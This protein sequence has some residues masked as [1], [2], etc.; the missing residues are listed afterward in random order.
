M[1]SAVKPSN[2]AQRL[3]ILRKYRVLDTSPE[4][5]FDEIVW[6]ASIICKVPVALISLI[7]QDRQWFKAKVGLEAMQ[8]HRD[9]AFC[10][11][12]I[13]EPTQLLE[14]KDALQDE[15]FASNPL[16]LCTPQVRFYAGAPLRTVSGEALGTLC[17][18]DYKPNAL[19]AEQKE[20]LRVLANQVMAQL[21]LRYALRAAKEQ[22]AGQGGSRPGSG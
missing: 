21:E 19:S 14:V 4:A 13:L 20:A 2:E 8:T 5:A 1:R 10:A 22:S 12:A 15:R 18:I 6:L 16:V 9:L 17:V 3:A 11:H 7:D